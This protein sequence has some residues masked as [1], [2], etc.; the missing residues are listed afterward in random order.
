MNKELRVW[1]IPKVPMK[2]FYVTVQSI[3]EAKKI[4]DVLADYD[5]FQFENNIKSD[6]SNT[7]GLEEWDDD[8]KE[9]CEWE[10]EEGE[11]IDSIN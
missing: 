2:P 1:W 8:L 11:T 4:L 3:S 5:L 10:S 6:Y 7:G 9:W